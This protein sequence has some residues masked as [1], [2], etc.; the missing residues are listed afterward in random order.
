ME[1]KGNLRLA[2]NLYIYALTDMELF[3]KYIDD[4]KIAIENSADYNGEAI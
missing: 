3:K 4:I 1:R 2:R